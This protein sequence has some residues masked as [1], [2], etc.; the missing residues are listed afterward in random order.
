M[1]DPQDSVQSPE[2]G[3]PADHPGVA[4]RQ[5]RL[6]SGQ[7]LAHYAVV[8]KISERRL[9]AFEEGRW[10][11]VGDIT[12]VRALAQ[13]LCRQLGMD[14]APVLAALPLA[15]SAPRALSDRGT[16][17][18]GSPPTQ[19]SLSRPVALPERGWAG[20]G[21]LTPIRVAVGLIL[22]GALAV[23]WLPEEWWGRPASPGQIV[24]EVRPQGMV[25]P[26]QAGSAPP[27]VAASDPASAASA[28]Q[29]SP[30]TQMQ[31]QMQTQTQTQTQPDSP[32]AG[33]LQVRATKDSWVR[34]TDAGGQVLIMRMMLAGE[35][36]GI[37][38]TRPLRLR[39]GNVPGTEAIW[40]GRRVPL[41]ATQVDGVAEV[42]L[43]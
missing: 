9:Q 32:T 21:W 14:P 28:V 35:S 26:E 38:G 31:T 34:V 10:S 40:L 5:A 17:A 18:A 15:Q 33:A 19:H 37:D 24:E 43:R 2:G 16:Q 1:T 29:P 39:V 6:A 3:A 30:Q 7:T 23:A 27:A 25:Q 13:R 22:L 36:V 12:F 4:L 42:E 8:L 41:E 20:R 11:D